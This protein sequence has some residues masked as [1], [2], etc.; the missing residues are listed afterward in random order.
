MKSYAIILNT[1]GFTVSN[2]ESNRWLREPTKVSAADNVSRQRMRYLRVDAAPSPMLPTGGSWEEEQN[3]EV[4]MELDQIGNFGA[5]DD[6]LESSLMDAFVIE[7][8]LDSTDESE[9]QLEVPISQLPNEIDLAL[10]WRKSAWSQSAASAF[11]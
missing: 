5:F 9:E 8:V 3:G 7:Q 4:M 10:H 2:A 6:E 1:L 11:S